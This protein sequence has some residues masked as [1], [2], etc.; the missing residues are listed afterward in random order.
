MSQENKTR[1][2]KMLILVVIV[3]T[4]S[5]V[6]AT[7]LQKWITDDVNPAVTAGVV[8]AITAVVASESMSKS[9]KKD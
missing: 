6:L 7:A 1:L 8:G 2:G 4:V 5:A 9:S 3:A